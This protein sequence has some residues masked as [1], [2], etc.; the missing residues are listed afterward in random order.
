MHQTTVRFSPELWSMLEREAAQSGVSVA[1]Y[2]RDAALARIAFSAGQRSAEH[3]LAWADPR[4]AGLAQ[5]QAESR[6]SLQAASAAKS[7][8][9]SGGGRA[10]ASRPRTPAQRQSRSAG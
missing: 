10:A 5:A 3:P 7:P 2:V 1:H 9:Q 6:E 4:L 8:A